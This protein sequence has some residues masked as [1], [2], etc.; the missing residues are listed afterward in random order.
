MATHA[1]YNPKAVFHPNNFIRQWWNC[2][3]RTIFVLACLLMAIGVLLSFASSLPAAQRLEIPN[4]FYFV[5]KQSVFATL[6]FFLMLGISFLNIDDA[7]RLSFVIYSVS[8]LLLSYV[9]LNGHDAKGARRW[10]R[11]MGFSLQPSEMIKP[12]ALVLISWVLTRRFYDRDF[13]GEWIALALVAMPIA[14]FLNQPD[15]G[16]TILLSLSFMAI[17]WV[18]GISIK[19]MAILGAIFASGFT[20]IFTFVPHVISRVK[21]FKNGGDDTNTQVSSGLDAI[22]NGNF[23]GQGLGE[24]E[25]KFSLPDCQT[26]FIFSLA[27]EEWG[28]LGSIFLICL[29]AALVIRGINSSSKQID[30]F[31]QTAGIALFLVLGLQVGINLAVNLNLIPAKGMTLPFISYGGSSLFGSAITIGLALAITKKRPGEKILGL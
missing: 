13:K 7:R 8:L 3:D 12:A 14:I 27:T 24:G 2:I 19:W 20:L 18:S 11:F 16:Q 25:I 4:Q 30:P 5:Y 21:V 17:F 10:I 28:F 22:S 6:A 23:F 31:A 26:D 9:F 15:V 1:I 29:F